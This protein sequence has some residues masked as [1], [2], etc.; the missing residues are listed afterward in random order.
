MP[1]AP[2]DRHQRTRGL[3][4]GEG[5]RAFRDIMPRTG[6]RSSDYSVGDDP[7]AGNELDRQNKGCRIY[8]GK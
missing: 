8:G 2:G 3:G 7:Q 1:R 6:K 5:G 4:A